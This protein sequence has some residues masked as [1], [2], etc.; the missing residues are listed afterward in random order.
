MLCI[1]QK[2]LTEI[3]FSLTYSQRGGKKLIWRLKQ[4]ECNRIGAFKSLFFPGMVT[5]IYNPEYVGGQHR[6]VASLRSA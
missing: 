2:D 4:L 5:H 6:Q 1:E 3:Y